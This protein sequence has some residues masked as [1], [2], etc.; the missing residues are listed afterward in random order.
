MLYFPFLLLPSASKK[1]IVASLTR[2]VLFYREAISDV[3][4]EADKRTRR[5]KVSV[6]S[7]LAGLVE[8]PGG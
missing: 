6:D 4:G 5:G 1:K 3:I 7:R 8:S 2:R